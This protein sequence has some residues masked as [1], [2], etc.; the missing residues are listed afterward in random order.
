VQELLRIAD[1]MAL[2]TLES[3]PGHGERGHREAIVIAY[4]TLN[5]LKVTYPKTDIAKVFEALQ[6][7][8]GVMDLLSR[9]RGEA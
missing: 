8:E 2:Y 7:A 3:A 6:E 5:M 1:R 4:L 9:P